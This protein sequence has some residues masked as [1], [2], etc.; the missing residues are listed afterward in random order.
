MKRELKGF[1]LAEVLITL[2]IIGVIASLTLPSLTINIVKQQTGPALAKAINSLENANRLAL[3]EGSARRLDQL[4][5][6]KNTYY[7]REAIKDYLDY[8]YESSPKPYYTY[9]SSIPFI[10]LSVMTTKDGISYHHEAEAIKGGTTQ[11]ITS[12]TPEQIKRLPAAYSGAYYDVWI[13]VNGN[14][15]GPNQQGKDLFKVLVDLKGSVIPYGG[16]AWSA[17]TGKNVEWTG[18]G[19]GNKKVHPTKP[20]SCA[21]SIAD[22]GFRVIY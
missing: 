13:D 16:Q 19:C 8:H 6:T 11:G 10:S 2:G 5:K 1:T 14:S 4:T 18:N 15:K 7:F 22:N 3:Q 20:L 17:Y 21:G 12:L 9:N